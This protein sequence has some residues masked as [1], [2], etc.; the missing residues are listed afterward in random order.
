VQLEQLKMLLRD[1]GLNA[2]STDV[3]QLCEDLELRGSR[4]TALKKASSADAPAPA[5]DIDEDHLPAKTSVDFTSF[6]KAVYI[7]KHK[8]S[9]TG[10]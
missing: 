1:S 6:A 5:A 3:A 8:P 9:V 2:S 7:L 4:R 10:V